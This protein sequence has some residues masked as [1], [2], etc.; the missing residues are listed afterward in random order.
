M[1]TEIDDE[2][3]VEEKPRKQHWEWI[4]PL[5][6]KPRST[7]EKIV[8]QDG[9]VWITPLLI[10]SLLIILMAVLAGPARTAA[11]TVPPPPPADSQYWSPE[12]W[13][14]YNKSLEGRGNPVLTMVLP[15]ATGLLGVWIGWFLLSA[16]LHLVLTISGRRANNVSTQNLVAWSS[17]PLGVRMIVQGIAMLVSRSV[18]KTSGMATL[19]AADATG[20]MLFLRVL[21]GL[22]DIYILWQ[23]VLLILGAGPMTNS[24]RRKVILPVIIAMILYLALLALPGVLGSMLGGLNTSGA[25]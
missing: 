25:M 11:A 8:K 1:N 17:L 9:A 4:L 14:Q 18:I 24:P 12:M 22:V 10:L 15:A 6:I 5:F 3:E 13:E 7:L 16:I 20:F 21:L 2:L 19:I 23:I